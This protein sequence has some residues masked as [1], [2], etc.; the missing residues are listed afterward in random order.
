MNSNHQ[1]SIVNAGDGWNDAAADYADNVL[2]G[3][4]IKCTDGFWLVGRD[5]TPLKADTRLV[6]LGT[7]AAWVKWQGNKP[8]EYRVR[9]PGERLPD[10]KELGDLDETQWEAGPDDKP[11]DPWQETRFVHFVDP[12]TAEAFTYSTSSW[13]G[14]NAV[15][16]LGDQITRMRIARPGAAPVVEFTS[17]PHMTK[18]GP[19]RKP[20][21]KVVGWVG[22]GD[23]QKQLDQLPKNADMDDVIPF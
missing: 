4:L 15:I 17:G 20:V 12:A 13:A 7:V 6:A 16:A 19:K 14:R 9:K 5:G 18:Y 11:R 2:R 8:A 21:L 10:R 1:F 3:T 23:E 22:G